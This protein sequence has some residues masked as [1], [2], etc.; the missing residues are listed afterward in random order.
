MY[1]NEYDPFNFMIVLLF[2]YAVLIG[3]IMML[4][5]NNIHGSRRELV[6]AL[7]NYGSGADADCNGTGNN[8]KRRNCIPAP[9]AIKG[10]RD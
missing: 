10:Q 5:Y 6:N 7:S 4:I 9:T 1:T 8:D 3:F 2:I